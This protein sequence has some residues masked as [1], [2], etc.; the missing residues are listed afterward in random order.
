MCE[1]LL[2]TRPCVYVYVLDNH[3]ELF[4]LVKKPHYRACGANGSSCELAIGNKPELFHVMVTV[5]IKVR[6]KI[7]RSATMAPGQLPISTEPKVNVRQ[8]WSFPA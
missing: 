6:A 1:L 3:V 2:R 8:E 7:I 5:L 4:L